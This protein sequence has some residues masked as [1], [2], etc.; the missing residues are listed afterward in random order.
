M[1]DIAENLA[2][3][4]NKR[5]KSMTVGCLGHSSTH[6]SLYRRKS[7]TLDAYK[8]IARFIPCAM[9]PFANA[10]FAFDAALA[11]IEGSVEDG[12]TQGTDELRAHY[13]TRIASFVS[14]FG[15]REGL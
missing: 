10:G 15:H 2:K 14:D 8:D 12:V 13:H 3:E 9:G 7:D 1:Q 6:I 4:N 5:S 11:R